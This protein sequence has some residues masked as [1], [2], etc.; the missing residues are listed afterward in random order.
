MYLRSHHHQ[1]RDAKLIS[2][3]TELIGG[4]LNA[5]DGI[6]NTADDRWRR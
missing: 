6:V 3:C 4:G 5:G 2:M 1:A